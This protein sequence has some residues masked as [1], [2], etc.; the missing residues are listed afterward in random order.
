MTTELDNERRV[1]NWLGLIAVVAIIA[2]VVSDQLGGSGATVGTLVVL[3][4]GC[5]SSLQT[6]RTR[7]AVQP[8]PG[9]QA[10]PAPPDPGTPPPWL[11]PAELI[12]EH[13]RIEGGR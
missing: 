9:T 12:A 1:T 6:R 2:A 4:G 7:A 11:P 5:A 10:A 8:D 13:D 3:A